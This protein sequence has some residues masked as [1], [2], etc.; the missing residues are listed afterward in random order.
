[1][2]TASSSPARA[3]DR[4][5]I[6]VPRTL[7][8][9]LRDRAQLHPDAVACI[10][11]GESEAV[12]AQLTF[13]EL[14]ARA[15]AIAARLQGLGAAGECVVLLYPP[16]L[17]F[18]GAFFGCLYAGALA[19]PA[20]VPRAKASVA[21]LLGI[22]ADSSARIILTTD[23]IAGR[24]QRIGDTSFDSVVCLSTDDTQPELARAWQE[25]A[26]AVGHVAYLQY[27]SGSTAVR[28][29][30]AL[31]HANVIANIRAIA[32]RFQHHDASV[33]VNWLPH[34]HDLGL[35]NG[36]LQPLLLGHPGVLLAPTAFVQQPIRWLNAISRYRGTY[37]SSPNFGYDLCVRRTTP[38][39][40]AALDLSSWQIAL[41]GAEP[42]RSQ[43]IDEFTAL[44]APCGFRPEA[45]YPAYGLAE[46]TLVVSGGRRDDL[47][48]AV[49]VDAAAF[50][51]GRFV[52]MNPGRGSRRLIG[53]GQPIGETDVAIVDPAT[54]LRCGAGEIGEIWV[55]GPGVALGYWKRD[56]ESA[57]SFRARIADGDGR[58]YLRTGDLGYKRGDELFIAGRLKDLI[59]IRGNNHYPQDIE[60]TIEQS[61]PAFR[62][63]C[64]AA[65]A[66]ETDGIEQLA[67]VSEVER[68]HLSSIDHE[69]LWRIAQNAIAEQHELQLHALALLKTGTIPRTTSGKIQ[70][71]KCRAELL[72][73]SLDV[74]WSSRDRQTVD[75]PALALDPPAAV[76]PAAPASDTTAASAASDPAQS[77]CEWL[78]GYADER[79]SSRL[80]DERRSIAPHVLLDFGNHGVLGL[81]VPRESGG[82]GL[83]YRDTMKVLEQLGA[84]DQTLAMMT[85]VHNVLGIVPILHHASAAVKNDWLPRLASG[86]DL[87]AF[88]LTEPAAGS[89]PQAIVS[90]GTPTADGAWLLHG[91]KSW[92]GTAGWASVIN[93]FVQ[94]L[95]A[96][97]ATQGISG[98]V[99]PRASAGLRMGPE[100]LTLGMR[101][102]VQ[103]TIF[104]EGARVGRDQ[105]LGDIG[106]GMKVAQEAMM[107]GRLAIAAACVGGLKRCA[108]LL[109]RYASRRTIST[110]RLLDNPVLIDRVGGWNAALAGLEGLVAHVADRLDRG[111]PV[112]PEAYVICKIAGAEW[113][114]RAAD[115]LVQFLGGRG[116]IETNV[117]AQ[118]LRDARVTRILEGPT[119][120]LTMFL[121][122]RVVHDG[123]VISELLQGL[124]AGDIARQLQDAARDIT[125]RCLSDRSRF[126][127]ADARRW[128]YALIGQVATDA[129][130]LACTPAA[131]GY[132]RAWAEERFAAALAAAV[133]SAQS[134]TARLSGDELFARVD[135]YSASIGDVEQSLDGEDTEL[136]AMLRRRT[137]RPIPP[138]E[139]AGQT[140]P[141]AAAARADAV[142]ATASA[143]QAAPEAEAASLPAMVSA[144]SA[145][146]A[147]APARVGGTEIEAFI[148]RW[149][150]RQLKVPEQSIHPS[151]SLFDYGVDSVMTVMLGASLEEWLGGEV[152]PEW[153]YDAPV[154]REFAAH[155]AARHRQI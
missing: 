49:H 117:A 73:G 56:E 99:V 76:R 85:I 54:G 46:A 120:P 80:M 10:H 137:E 74:V 45:M 50:D 23:S 89:N 33:C 64:V 82:T 55:H 122:S 109:V 20:P 119:E 67:V 52:E 31:S 15:R 110:G 115:D 48:V 139:T 37:A 70:R 113:L 118:L 42:V 133:T 75:E 83:G 95:D 151:R 87:V 148:V 125:D 121:G 36:I 129:V 14:D 103:N 97:G 114:W 38:E 116:Y 90:T 107:Q 140:E 11:L 34:T 86:R 29:G 134:K 57:L 2:A 152:N 27:T 155:I 135:G 26:I 68:D 51:A 98:F 16:G 112:P 146:S 145:A 5:T 63:G 150:A 18:I 43:T 127:G 154:I 7:V 104:L 128:A 130:L 59:I 147:T 19:V 41:N 100:A 58:G 3:A 69:Q 17:E 91:Q 13:G 60:W 131:T 32:E 101:G 93:V 96:G 24:L 111:S 40:R 153:V 102:M 92:S 136:D 81:L 149:L 1:M 124:G 9:L 108:Q 21:P 44:F 79:L 141:L 143:P 132:A 39:Q 106:G 84:I 61:H 72:D 35:V 4:Q 88:A 28:K 78:R 126:G 25:P 142:S 30:V 22:I 62:P 65:F 123:A 105:A 66:L 8:Q 6:D 71:R 53:C 77:L 12:R 144:P 47:P 94:T 138:I